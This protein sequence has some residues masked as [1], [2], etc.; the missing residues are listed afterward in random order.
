MAPF[1]R[2]VFFIRLLSAAAFRQTNSSSLST[3][4]K[5][6]INNTNISQTFMEVSNQHQAVSLRGRNGS[7]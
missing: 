4:L 7:E 5:I 6:E 2:T 1:C 3:F